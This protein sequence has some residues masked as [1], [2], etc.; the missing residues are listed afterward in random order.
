M[1]KRPEKSPANTAGSAEKPSNHYTYWT[2]AEIAF[3]EKHYGR[4]PARDIATTLGRG[5]AAVRSMALKVGVGRSG[6]KHGLSGKLA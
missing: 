6:A 2:L 3:V 5:I 4:M 1:S